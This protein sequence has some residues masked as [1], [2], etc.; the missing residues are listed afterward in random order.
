MTKN[1]LS[2]LQ[3]LWKWCN[4]VIT[5]KNAKFSPHVANNT[6]IDLPGLLKAVFLICNSCCSLWGDDSSLPSGFPFRC[7]YVVTSLPAVDRTSV[8]YRTGL[9]L[10]R[11][12]QALAVMLLVLN[13]TCNT[14]NYCNH[15]PIGSESHN[16]L[17]PI[18]LF[19]RVCFLMDPSIAQRNGRRIML[20]CTIAKYNDSMKYGCKEQK[21]FLAN[22]KIQS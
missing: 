22:K 7:V 13:L 11:L 1:S 21:I 6:K 14:V 8:W 15:D 18:D 12:K 20:S 4:P 10:L 17:T 19:P 5:Y 16:N 9:H 3:K 2:C